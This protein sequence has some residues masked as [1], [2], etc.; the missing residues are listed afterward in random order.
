MN[1][2]QRRQARE[3]QKAGLDV[4][5]IASAMGLPVALVRAVLP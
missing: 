4:W 2:R 1:E 3:L 5:A